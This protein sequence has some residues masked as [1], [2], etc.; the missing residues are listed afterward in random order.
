MSNAGKSLPDVKLRT[1]PQGGLWSCIVVKQYHIP[2]YRNNC[3]W[4]VRN[5]ENTV[6]ARGMRNSLLAAHNSA[7]RACKRRWPTHGESQEEE[8]T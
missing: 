4:E 1:D 8:D 6:V 2:S 7:Y 5:P 3:Y